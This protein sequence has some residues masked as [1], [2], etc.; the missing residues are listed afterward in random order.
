MVSV[1]GWEKLDDVRDPVEPNFWYPNP[2]VGVL[3][4]IDLVTADNQQGRFVLS[5][6]VDAKP[7][8]IC[9]NRSAVQAGGVVERIYVVLKEDTR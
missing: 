3:D 1:T 8:G 9:T 4:Q 2:S 5:A 7:F 6:F